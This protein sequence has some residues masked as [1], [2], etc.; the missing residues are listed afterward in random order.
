MRAPPVLHG[1]AGYP[2]PRRKTLPAEGQC[3]WCASPV[4]EAA[5]LGDVLTDSFTDHDQALIPSSPWLCAACTWAMTGRPPDTLRLWSVMWCEDFERAFEL[6]ALAW[7]SEP[8]KIKWSANH[9]AAPD[10]GLKV[11]L[12]NKANTVA[13]RSLLRSPPAGRWLCSIADSG[14]IHTL[15]F[16]TVNRGAGRYAV[17][18]ERVTVYATPEQYRTIDDS[19]SRLMAAGFSKQDIADQPFPSRLL[20][21]GVDLWRAE[22]QVL[23]PFRG[24]PLFDLALF[25]ARKDQ[26]TDDRRAE[27]ASSNGTGARDDAQRAE[28]GDPSPRL[29]GPSEERAGGRRDVI[30]QLQLF[31]F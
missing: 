3:W 4:T 20:K 28:G 22:Q 6:L 21:C 13:F 5:R 10:L 2:D 11:H 14:Q 16:A 17:R 29:V 31:D 24:A 23:C 1:A 19:I 26:P 15:P 30:E 8:L 9:E 25:L 18:F 12:H 27:A 7:T